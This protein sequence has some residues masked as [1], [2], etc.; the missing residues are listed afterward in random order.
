[1]I[2]VTSFLRVRSSADNFA[3][4]ARLP[5]ALS[6]ISTPSGPGACEARSPIL[7]FDEA[8]E[9]CFRR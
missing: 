8:S 5:P 4:F 9:E 3:A 1:M 6:Q 2:A 7:S